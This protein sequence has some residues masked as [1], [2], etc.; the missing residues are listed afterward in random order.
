MSQTVVRGLKNS[1]ETQKKKRTIYEILDERYG[2]EALNYEVP[3]HANTVLFTLGGITLASLLV[4]LASGFLLGFWYLPFP[5]EA[6]L[7]IRTI[8]EKAFLGSVIRGIH[9]WGA[10]ITIAGLVLHILRVLFFGSYK[11]PREGNWIVGVLLFVTM[12]GLYFT[13]TV[14]KYDQEGYE[15]L[16][17][18]KEIAGTLGFGTFFNTEYVPTTI[19]IFLTHVSILPVIL[20]VLLFIHILLIKRLKIS[21]LPWSKA[22][23]N[24]SKEGGTQGKPQVKQG[25][26]RHSFFHHIRALIG[27]GYVV[28]GITLILGIIAPPGIGPSPLDGIEVTKP[29]WPFLWLYSVEEWFGVNGAWIAG[30]LT[31]AGLLAIPFIDYAK[32]QAFGKRKFVLILSTV[33]VLTFLVLTVYAYFST[34]VVHLNM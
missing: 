7:S 21:P 15:A 13:G 25:H 6:N 2:F 10:Q 26:K 16:A 18:A 4:T 31:V 8:M 28:L 23:A 17:H 33:V 29:V 20:L 3:P 9:F 27:W 30:G 11:R 32:E 24:G 22:E 12:I 14:L 19:R 34:P 5:E 1:P